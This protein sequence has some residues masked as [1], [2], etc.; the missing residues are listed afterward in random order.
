MRPG[1]AAPLRACKK[2]GPGDRVRGMNQPPS[3]ETDITAAQP[4]P[5]VRAGGGAVLAAGALVLLV[6][7]QNFT[8]F[9]LST[10]ATAIL[11]VITPL[12]LASAVAGLM[13]MRARAGSAVAGLVAS[14]LLFLAS[15][16]WLLFSLSG[17]LF[18]LFALLAPGVALLAIV[19]SA[20][21]LGPCHRVVKARARLAAQGFDLGM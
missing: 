13:L 8:G 20:V 10:T 9:I 17:G 14:G 11:L 1:D 12:G 7:L 16:G 5:V 21:S 6:A 2:T 4:P 15:T 3:S 19:L 18:S